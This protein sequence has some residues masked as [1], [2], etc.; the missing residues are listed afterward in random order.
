MYRDESFRMVCEIINVVVTTVDNVL[1]LDST[2][3]EVPKSTDTTL[4]QYQVTQ[5]LKTGESEVIPL[6]LIHSLQE[7]GNDLSG[8]NSTEEIT[9]K[10]VVV[11]RVVEEKRESQ[12]KLT[13]A[14]RHLD[15]YEGGGSSHKRSI[16]TS[17]ESYH[18]RRDR[19]PSRERSRE[20]SNSLSSKGV[21][22]K[23]K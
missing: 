11:N 17:D 12:K 14:N 13:E 18:S 1:T 20:R 22:F 3:L 5:V 9:K 15:E 10:N 21:G 7:S 8:E 4:H 19:S 2:L 16:E 6:M 23:R